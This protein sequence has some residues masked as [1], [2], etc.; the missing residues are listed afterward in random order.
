MS[1][2]AR[3]HGLNESVLK[4]FPMMSE[5]EMV[6]SCYDWAFLSVSLVNSLDLN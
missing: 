4:V 2:D 1:L 5:S 6:D 3:T